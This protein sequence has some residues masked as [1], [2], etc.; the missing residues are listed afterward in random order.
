MRNLFSIAAI[1]GLLITGCGFPGVFDGSDDKDIL[2][3][4][5]S[6]STTLLS[7]EITGGFAGVQQL[8]AVD[9]TGRIVFTNDFFPGAT[10][11][12]QMTEQELDNF[13]EL[14]RDNNFFS[15]A[16]EYIDSQVADAFLYAISYSSKTVRTDNFAAPQNLRNIIAGILQLINATRFS[17]LELTLALSAD[18]IR[19][20]GC[21]D[22]TLNVTNAG[23]DAFTLHFND[24]QIFDFLALTVQGEKDPV[25]VWN[26]AHDKAFT[27]ALWDLT[28]QPG[29][30]RSYQ[31]TWDGTNN[32]GDAMTGEFIMRAELV[33]TPG[34]SPEQKTL[35]IRE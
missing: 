13:D 1:L 17:E 10:W 3:S 33:S 16:S 7:V 24:G 19:S 21:V 4:N 34:G 11:T 20:G 30:S 26:W 8:L 15:L 14:M 31:V 25:L 18:E 22:M 23:Q 29:D 32:A 5:S 28:L 12:R 6:P 2:E 9:E 27:A 35:A